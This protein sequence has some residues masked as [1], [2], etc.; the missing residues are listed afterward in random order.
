MGTLG[1]LCRVK[2][3]RVWSWPLTSIQCR[4]DLHL[5]FPI[6]FTACT[7]ENLTSYLGDLWNE[8]NLK[9]IGSSLFSILSHHFPDGTEENHEESQS[10]QSM[11]WAEIQNGHLPGAKLQTVR[12]YSVTQN[13]EYKKRFCE[14]TFFIHPGGSMLGNTDFANVSPT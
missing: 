5:R 12:C 13:C 1:S 6:A 2:T 14:I 10:L 4:A 9:E 7:E 3:A 8:S 11:C